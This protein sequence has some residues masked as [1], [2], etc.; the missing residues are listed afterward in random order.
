MN[1]GCRSVLANVLVDSLAF[2]LLAIGIFLVLLVYLDLLWQL[3]H[4]RQL[5][6]GLRGLS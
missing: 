1:D 5:H 4:F 6:S 2:C 3:L